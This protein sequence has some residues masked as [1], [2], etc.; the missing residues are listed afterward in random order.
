[1]PTKGMKVRYANGPM[2][3]VGSGATSIMKYESDLRG[4][5]NKIPTPMKGNTAI[6]AG[7]YGEGRV[8]LISAHPESPKS[9]NEA[10]DL[11]VR[12]F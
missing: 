8:V 11:V 9:P 5:A 3:E 4:Q 12:L 1:M 10:H 2:L 7:M 6:A